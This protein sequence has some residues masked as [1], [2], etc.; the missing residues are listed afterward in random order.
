MSHFIAQA[1]PMA[2]EIS[3]GEAGNSSFVLACVVH[4]L[5]CLYK[6]NRGLL[7]V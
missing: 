1:S 6:K 2:R 5:Y 3:K 4:S 7:V